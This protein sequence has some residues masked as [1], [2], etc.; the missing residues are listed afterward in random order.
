MVTKIKGINVKGLN[1]RQAQAMKRHSQHHTKSHIDIMVKA[2]I[3]GKTFGE[4]H[5]I[6]MKK[7]GK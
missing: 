5:T 4:S 3:K 1:K 2:M 7:V 6:A